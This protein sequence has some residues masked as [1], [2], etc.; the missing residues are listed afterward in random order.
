MYLY[1]VFS[2]SL[3]DP[4]LDITVG[5][6]INIPQNE[7]DISKGDFPKE[8]HFHVKRHKSLDIPNHKGSIETWCQKV[9]KEKEEKLKK[10]YEEKKFDCKDSKIKLV[11]E[12]EIQS[13]FKFANIFW[14]IF[15]ISTLVLLVYAPIIR[16]FAL[17]SITVFVLISKYGGIQVLLD[18]EL[19]NAKQKQLT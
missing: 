10:F 17:L 7:L 8:V 3:F 14:T 9:W 19:E 5:Y 2:A 13:L 1:F 18:S 11:D 6:P 15:Q 4:I 16:W 12:R